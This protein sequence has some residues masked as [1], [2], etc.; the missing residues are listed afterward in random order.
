VDGPLDSEAVTRFKRQGL[1][2]FTLHDNTTLSVYTMIY[3]LAN[4]YHFSI[5][6]QV[7]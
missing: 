4:K 1:L 6:S 3:H 5:A 2:V 7:A